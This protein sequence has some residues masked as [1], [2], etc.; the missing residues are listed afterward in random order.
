MRVQGQVQGQQ[1]REGKGARRHKGTRAQGQGRGQEWININ[2]SIS[3]SRSSTRG[4]HYND[5][6]D[7]DAINAFGGTEIPK[8]R[9][10]RQGQLRHFGIDG[11]NNSNGGKGN[12]DS[13]SNDE[14]GDM[15]THGGLGCGKGGN[16]LP[17]R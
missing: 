17:R 2:N 8:H 4:V 12:C 5:N 14:E 9:Q 16:S 13:C 6:D 7:D 15:G 10:S 1:G 3:G 11:G